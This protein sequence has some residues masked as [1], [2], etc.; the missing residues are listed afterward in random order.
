MTRLTRLSARQLTRKERTARAPKL[1]LLCGGAVVLV[2]ALGSLL[3]P[4]VGI[5]AAVAAGFASLAAFLARDLAILRIAASQQHA[6]EA[7]APFR[8]DEVYPLNPA[9]LLPENALF[10]VQQIFLHRPRQVLE[11]GSGISMV[12]IAR[13]LAQL[14]SEDCKLYSLEHHEEWCT[15]TRRTLEREGLSDRVEL[16]HAPR[17]ATS[18][19]DAPW[20]DLSV[21][22]PEAGPFDLVLVDGPEAGSAEPLARAGAFPSIRDRLAPGCV[23]LLDDGCR[24]GERQVA[25]GWQRLEPRLRTSFHRSQ[26]GMW[27]F[28]VP[29]S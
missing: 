18:G 12:F 15:V 14:G 4:T 13:A 26:H 7:I 24:G 6:L 28:E 22:P 1:A 20:Y 10:L 27:L 8:G 17:V 11:F 2:G 16:L 3:G 23:I 9:T 29:A 5:I 19:L 25:Q 21:L